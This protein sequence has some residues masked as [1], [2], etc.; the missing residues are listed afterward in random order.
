MKDTAYFLTSQLQHVAFFHAHG[1]LEAKRE[2]SMGPT[3]FPITSFY[4]PQKEA[5][6]LFENYD[7]ENTSAKR[8]L[9]SYF[10]LR[11]EVYTPRGG[12]DR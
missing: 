12:V 4:F 9:D 3:G 7:K 8:L 5:M 2:S 10:S 1:L 11:K 6:A